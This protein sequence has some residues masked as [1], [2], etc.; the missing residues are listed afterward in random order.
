MVWQES[1]EY[2]TEPRP[3]L[4]TEPRLVLTNNSTYTVQSTLA[5]V[6]AEEIPQIN[7]YTRPLL[8][9]VSDQSVDDFLVRITYQEYILQATGPITADRFVLIADTGGNQK[10][11]A[12]SE[13]AIS[14]QNGEQLV[15][16][17]SYVKTNQGVQFNGPPGSN[18]FSTTIAAF[19]Q[20]AFNSNV[21]VSLTSSSQY[22]AAGVTAL[23]NSGSIEGWY[24][25]QSIGGTSVTLKHL[26]LG[27]SAAPGTIMPA[28]GQLIVA[29]QPGPPGNPGGDQ[30]GGNIQIYRAELKG[31]GPVNTGNAAFDTL[32]V[33]N[34]RQI[35]CSATSHTNTNLLSDRTDPIEWFTRFPVGSLL[36]LR[37][38]A[39]TKFFSGNV[40][41][42]TIDS[43][44][45]VDLDAPITAV[46]APF[47]DLEAINITLQRPI[48]AASTPVFDTI[49]EKVSVAH[50]TANIIAF[51]VPEANT[52]TVRN[53]TQRRVATITGPV[54]YSKDMDLPFAEGTSSGGRAAADTFADGEW[55][56]YIIFKDDLTTFDFLGTAAFTD[57]FNLVPKLPPGF[58][59]WRR[60][61][62]FPVISSAVTPFYMSGEWYVRSI[63]A[64]QAMDAS[65]STSGATLTLFG[66]TDFNCDAMVLLKSGQGLTVNSEFTCSL[67]SVGESLTGLSAEDG[68]Q[69]TSIAYGHGSY[70][71]GGARVSGN[72]ER[73]IYLNAAQCLIFIGG[74]AGVAANTPSAR[75][76]RIDLS[77]IRNR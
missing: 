48:P 64:D 9:V 63:T 2:K 34:I 39:A 19:T 55:Y 30:G 61:L 8:T 58:S 7:G 44:I 4:S 69:N 13:R 50:S 21:V 10:W 18:A 20:P 72:V 73:V 29:G 24:E 77:S 45:Q 76:Q 23:Y 5:Q 75:T 16:K 70:N 1:I 6:L 22:L 57:N 68:R 53:A 31:T 60:L 56:S 27:N 37:N 41:A 74:S 28:G 62:W 49:Q 12:Y 38:S 32:T 14:L 33:A 25:V 3:N 59:W 40:S 71:V 51:T 11:V 66:P 36:I 67:V 47:T 46:G 26:Q 54:T 65:S 35:I 15:F 43:S 52:I 42:I 17:L